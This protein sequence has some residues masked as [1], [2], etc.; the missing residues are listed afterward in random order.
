MIIGRICIKVKPRDIIRFLIDQF[1]LIM[2]QIK[3]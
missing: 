3:I 2:G 1:D